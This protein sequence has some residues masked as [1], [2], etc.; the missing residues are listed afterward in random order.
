M[1]VHKQ[2]QKLYIGLEPRYRSVLMSDIRDTETNAKS[3]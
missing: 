3:L 1:K 2:V